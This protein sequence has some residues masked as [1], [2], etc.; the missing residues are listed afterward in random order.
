M[1]VECVGHKTKNPSGRGG[2]QCAG[3]FKLNCAREHLPRGKATTSGC[4]SLQSQP[5]DTDNFPSF[6][7]TACSRPRT[8]RF[9]STARPNPGHEPHQPFQAPYR[10]RRHRPAQ[11]NAP[12]PRQDFPN[13]TSRPSPL[14]GADGV[15][16]RQAL[17]HPIAQHIFARSPLDHS[18]QRIGRVVVFLEIQHL[19]PLRPHARQHI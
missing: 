11:P 5:E 19:Q 15:A 8:A 13:A 10:R 17:T 3:N 4:C 7:P 1:V 16:M 14:P 18:G 9:R 2:D 6:V 12:Q